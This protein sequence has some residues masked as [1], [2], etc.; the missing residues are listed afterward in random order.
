VQEKLRVLAE[1]DAA[2][3]VG[4]IIGPEGNDREYCEQSGSSAQDRI[5]RSLAL[6]LD[7]EIGADL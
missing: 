5:V 7:A 3:D 6:G 4:G 1:T 2:A